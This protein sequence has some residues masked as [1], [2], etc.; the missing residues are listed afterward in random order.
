MALEN[1]AIFW[2]SWKIQR[3]DPSMKNF[4]Q[5]IFNS[6]FNEIQN[7]KSLWPKDFTLKIWAKSEMKI[8]WNKFFIE[9]SPLW[10]FQEIQKITIFSKAID[11]KFFLGQ[12]LN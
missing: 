8:F 2:I 5:K 1:I 7:L 3:G 9:G 4:S 10:I 12:F 11:E 6:D